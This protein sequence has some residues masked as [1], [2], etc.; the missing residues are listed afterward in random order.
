MRLGGVIKSQKKVCPFLE[1]IEK[2]YQITMP[3]LYGKLL[4]YVIPSLYMYDN[5]SG[6]GNIFTLLKSISLFILGPS[7]YRSKTILGWP[8]TFWTRQEPFGHDSQ[9]KNQ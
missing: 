1:S 8:K 3:Y 6:L 5:I 7:F 4:I 2:W 9:T